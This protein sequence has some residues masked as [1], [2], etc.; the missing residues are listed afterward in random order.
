[1]CVTRRETIK[2]IYQ[3]RENYAINLF[4]DYYYYF[5]YITIQLFS[6]KSHKVLLYRRRVFSNISVQLFLQE[7]GKELT[8]FSICTAC[9]LETRDFHGQ[10]YVVIFQWPPLII[11]IGGEQT[12]LRDFLR[13]RSELLH[14]L[15]WIFLWYCAEWC[16]HVP[17][18]NNILLCYPSQ[19][20][21]K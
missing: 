11:D 7:L 16:Q 5:I 10:N 21:T 17:V 12:F 8:F 15:E 4:I 13:G 20:I 19:R 6:I 1:M 14:D 2:F 9:S 3:V 18:F